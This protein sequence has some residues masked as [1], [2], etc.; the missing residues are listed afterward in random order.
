MPI[1]NQNS[2]D[3]RLEISG[4]D[5]DKVPMTDWRN[6]PDVVP[7]FIRPKER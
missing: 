2:R 5:G 6:L 7:P 4:A 3:G 1:E